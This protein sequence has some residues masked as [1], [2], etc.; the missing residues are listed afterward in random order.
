[1][2]TKQQLAMSMNM[3]YCGLYDGRTQD[4]LHAQLGLKSSQKISD[5][6]GAM[7]PFASYMRAVLGSRNIRMCQVDNARV[8]G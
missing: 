4:D 3:G 7:G 8:A 1:V 6:I 5:N 2:I